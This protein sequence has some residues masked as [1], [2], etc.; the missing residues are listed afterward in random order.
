MSRF[1]EFLIAG[2]SALTIAAQAIAESPR[3]EID[4]AN[5]SFSAAF[6]AGDAATASAHYSE[7]AAI[8]PPGSA[9]IDGRTQIEA[10]WKGA[11]EAGVTNVVLNVVE[12]VDAGDYAF[13]AGEASLSAPDTS[14]AVVSS[15]IK[16]IVVWKQEDGGDWKIYRDIWNENVL[17]K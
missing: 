16:Y 14:G 12:V 11:I 4:A 10:Y 13:E 3:D 2:S 1:A 5:V 8:L 9:R 6:N 17:P 15:A 7:D